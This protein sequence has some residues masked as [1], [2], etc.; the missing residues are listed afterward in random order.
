MEKKNQINNL[1]LHLKQ[2]WKKKNSNINKLAE[3][4][5]NYKDQKEINEK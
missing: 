2:L 3:G 5:K 1:A 4:K